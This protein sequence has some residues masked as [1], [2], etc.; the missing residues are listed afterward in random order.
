MVA[1]REG[2]TV[3][4]AVKLRSL[5]A[6]LQAWIKRSFVLE[7]WTLCWL[8]E[9]H[10]FC[11][12]YGPSI[13]TKN[14]II[15]IT[16]GEDKGNKCIELIVIFCCKMCK[17]LLWSWH[18]PW[19]HPTNALKWSFWKT[20]WSSRS[21]TSALSRQSSRGDWNVILL[22]VRHIPGGLMLML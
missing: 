17:C 10:K 3:P 9:T 7:R 4:L 11:N 5:W 22:I 15:A 13:N 21:A 20:K 12:T 14:N 18:H 2:W 8:E 6:C 1:V 16:M 19:S